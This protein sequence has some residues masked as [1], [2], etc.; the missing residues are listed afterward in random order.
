MSQLVGYTRKILASAISSIAD[1]LEQT[2]LD[3]NEAIHVLSSQQSTKQD[4]RLRSE[5]T[6]T[7]A[8]ASIAS[9]SQTSTAIEPTSAVNEQ[10]PVHP[11]RSVQPRHVCR[12]VTGRSH[13]IATTRQP[14]AVG[15]SPILNVRLSRSS[16]LLSA[17]TSHHLAFH[18]KRKKSSPTRQCASKSPSLDSAVSTSMSA[19]MSTSS[20]CLVHIPATARDDHKPAPD[21]ARHGVP[22]SGSPV[23]E[24]ITRGT[25]SVEADEAGVAC[26]RIQPSNVLN[27]IGQKRPGKV[28]RSQC[29]TQHGHH[30]EATLNQFNA[31]WSS[32]KV[33]TGT[34]TETETSGALVLTSSH[35]AALTRWFSLR[36]FTQVLSFAFS[37][38]ANIVLMFSEEPQSVDS[39]GSRSHRRQLSIT[40]DNATNNPAT[41][42]HANATESYSA[43]TLAV[44]KE[45]SSLESPMLT[46]AYS[47]ESFEIIESS[48]GGRTSCS[49][50]DVDSPSDKS[51]LSRLYSDT[52]ATQTEA[53]GC[54][55]AEFNRC[56][57]TESLTA[58]AEFFQFN[59]KDLVSNRQ[60]NKLNPMGGVRISCPE[61]PDENSE[62]EVETTPTTMD[63]PNIGAEGAHGY[64][65]AAKKS[66]LCAVNEDIDSNDDDNDDDDDDGSASFTVLS[67]NGDEEFIVLEMNK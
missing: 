56:Q 21:G 18:E 47:C 59:F 67:E 6:T 8:T 41:Y 26:T 31:G 34:Q 35:E 11:S 42:P 39:T 50:Q 43:I 17:D 5:S 54:R 48:S 65:D 37:Q 12:D 61:F 36:P 44:S 45:A 57:D 52:N 10:K 2:V 20:P 22:I 23:S 62:S 28:V 30:P 7:A 24:V 9:P 4:G 60:F 66:G 3:F 58:S 49:P 40:L 55:L 29:L 64:P 25:S 33:D 16:P 19:S 51:F 53:S 15:F 1:E 14:E 13:N 38:F 32:F 27:R 63:V 46:S